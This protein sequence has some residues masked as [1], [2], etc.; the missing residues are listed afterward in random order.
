MAGRAPLATSHAAVLLDAHDVREL[1]TCV[2]GLTITLVRLEAKL[3]RFVTKQDDF[4]AEVYRLIELGFA[5][6]DD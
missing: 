5:R 2:R 6:V 1:A 4:C 3:G